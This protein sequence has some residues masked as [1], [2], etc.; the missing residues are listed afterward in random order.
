[1]KMR[2][3]A[4]P[5]FC[6]V[7]MLLAFYVTTYYLLAR[8]SFGIAVGV[9]PWNCIP[10]YLIFDTQLQFV[11]R[12]IHSIDRVLRPSYWGQILDADDLARRFVE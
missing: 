5:L 8:A 1:M 9:G 10:H 12:P 7:L 11:Y 6:A 4:S 2:P 3:K